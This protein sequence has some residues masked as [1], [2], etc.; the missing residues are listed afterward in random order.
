MSLGTASSRLVSERTIRAGCA[1][2]RVNGQSRDIGLNVRTSGHYRYVRGCVIHGH[3]LYDRSLADRRIINSNCGRRGRTPSETSD[4][5]PVVI[6]E[7]E[8]VGLLAPAL[9]TM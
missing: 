9:G 8:V 4:E 5:V 2:A 6:T 3:L 1:I 7:Y